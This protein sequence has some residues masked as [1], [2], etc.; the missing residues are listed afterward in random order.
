MNYGTAVPKRRENEAEQ[1]KSN[2][3]QRNVHKVVELPKE[4]LHRIRRRKHNPFKIG[5][6]ALGAAVVSFVVG[7]IIVGQVQ[8]TELNQKI[9]SA[10]ETLTDA[11]SVYIQNEMKVEGKLSNE[12]IESYAKNELGMTK[13]SNAQKEF[14][15][16]ESG[17]KA[18]VSAQEDENIFTQFIESLQNLWS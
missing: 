17:D 6:G 18:E 11:Q 2:K 3:R 9:I 10:Q 14:I 7:V 5:V 4:E 8:L 16:I 12:E 1:R 13:A 15:A